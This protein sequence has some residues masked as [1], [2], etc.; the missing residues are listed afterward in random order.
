MIEYWVTEIESLRST[1]LYSGKYQ[2]HPL[3][4]QV[5]CSLE[6]Y[7]SPSRCGKCGYATLLILSGKK[8]QGK[9]R[10][11]FIENKIEI[12]SVLYI[13]QVTAVVAEWYK[14]RTVACLVM[15]SSLVPLKTRREGQ[16]CML[17]MSRAETSS[18]FCG[19]VVR[20]TGASS[21]VVHVT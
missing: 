16:Q 8:L 19:I 5:L 7:P 3:Q 9:F 6:S 14:Y 4:S 17:N 13:L 11:F 2:G 21:G 20:R 12:Y 10:Y 15:S 18:P 1:V